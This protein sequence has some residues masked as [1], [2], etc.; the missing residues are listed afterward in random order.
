MNGRQFLAGLLAVLAVALGL[1]GGVARYVDQRVVQPDAFA[2]SALDALDR[3]AVR[4]A[5]ADE[6]AAR[7]V[8]RVPVELVPR[9]QVRRVADRVVAT[10]AFRRT[11]RA[12]ALEAN[13]VLFSGDDDAAAATLSLGDLTPAFDAIDP[14][15]A[16]LLGDSA[17]QRLLTLRTDTLGVGTA[18]L[19]DAA[20]TLGTV[21]P[22]L[23][24][25][26]L[27]AALLISPRR[28]AVVRIAALG[29]VLAGALLLAGLSVGRAFA[30]DRAEASAGITVAQARD[31]VGAAW[32]VYL[33]G[34]RPWALAAIAVGLVLTAL[35][36]LPAAFGRRERT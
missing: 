1:V 12:R 34:L 24:A 32:D 18:R 9:A 19:G 29:S 21:G 15:L 22:L 20:S 2:Q 33:D 6:I 5:V 27:I 31:A 30:L 10:R 17:E 14:R 11:F 3:A 26:A 7:V 13:R 8:E 25:L 28:L 16:P 36:L 23:A 4:A 35:T